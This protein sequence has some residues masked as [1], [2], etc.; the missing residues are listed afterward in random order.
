MFARMVVKLPKPATTT[1]LVCDMQEKFRSTIRYFKEITVVTKRL[2]DC[3]SILGMR[4]IA[5]EQYP[6]GLGHTIR[7]LQLA[8]QGIPIFEKKQF[9]MCIPSVVE[10]LGSPESVILCGIEAHVCVLGTALDLLGRGISVHLVVDAVSSRT[11]FDRCFALNRIQQAGG[12]LTTSESVILGLLGGADH[13]KFREVQKL[14]MEPA[15]D[16]GISSL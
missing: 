3:A 16:T 9:S 8:D 7:E 10:T 13:E 1:L 6:K 15:P 12:V 2:I 5:T 14:I 4:V 11:Q